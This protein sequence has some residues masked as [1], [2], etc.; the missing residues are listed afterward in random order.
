MHFGEIEDDGPFGQTDLVQ[1]RPQLRSGVDVEI[2]A[3]MNDIEP[4]PLLGRDGE[5][6]ALTFLPGQDPTEPW[7]SCW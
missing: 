7:W 3:G 5:I 1:S 4:V 6:H 2:P